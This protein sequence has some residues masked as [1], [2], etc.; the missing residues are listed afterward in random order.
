MVTINKV[1]GGLETVFGEDQTQIRKTQSDDH[2]TTLQ[3]PFPLLTD[4]YNCKAEPE[5]E[6]GD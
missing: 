6:A 4:R 2:K 5:L 1:H 3:R